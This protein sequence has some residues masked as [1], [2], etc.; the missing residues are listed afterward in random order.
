MKKV[1]VLIL[2]SALTVCLSLIVPAVLADITVTYYWSDMVDKIV[3]ESDAN[4]DIRMNCRGFA[5]TGACVQCGNCHTSESQSEILRKLNQTS[6]NRHMS[7]YFPRQTY[8]LSE[9]QKLLWD[10]EGGYYINQ[11]NR[12][13]RYTKDHK[14]IWSAPPGSRILKSKRGEP[15][16][17]LF[18]GEPT[19]P[20]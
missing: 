7:T 20:R 14:L 5:A 12:L 2:I 17:L 13:L 16:M 6:W 9:G 4:A 15:Y 19:K 10:R 11:R 1:K 18:S 8:S 3:Y